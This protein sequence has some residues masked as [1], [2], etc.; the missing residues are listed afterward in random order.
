MSNRRENSLKQRND[1][2]HR[3]VVMIPLAFEC[4]QGFQDGVRDGPLS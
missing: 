3:S 1:H 2:C 4:T